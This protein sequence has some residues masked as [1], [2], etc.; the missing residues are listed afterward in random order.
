[1]LKQ[2]EEEVGGSP[3]LFSPVVEDIPDDIDETMSP[4]EYIELLQLGVDRRVISATGGGDTLVFIHAVEQGRICFHI[5][6][7]Y[8]YPVGTDFSL[9]IGLRW[10]RAAALGGYMQ[11]AYLFP[12]LQHQYPE[13]SP[14]P[15]Q[16]RLLLAVAGLTR[17][18]P[19][20]DILAS[21]WPAHYQQLMGVIQDQHTIQLQPGFNDVYHM[22]TIRNSKD[23]GQRSIESRGIWDSIMSY[24][25]DRARCLLEGQADN[26]K[27]AAT[28]DDD[29]AGVLHALTYLR[30][31]DAAFLA[32]LAVSKGADLNAM[33]PASQGVWATRLDEAT[34]TSALSPAIPRGQ[35]LFARTMID[36]HEEKDL[37]IKDF[38]R[39]LITSVV[40]W[41][42][43]LA[44]AL[45]ELRARRPSLCDGTPPAELVGLV[46]ES[47]VT[48]PRNLLLASMDDSDMHSLENRAFHGPRHDEAY[49]NTLMLLIKHGAN[50]TD[51]F[52][53]DCPLYRCL[54]DDDPIA[55]RCF[56]RYLRETYD[57]D[58]FQRVVDPGHCRGQSWSANGHTG[59][60]T[61]IYSG[62]VSISC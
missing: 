39:A 52:F 49:A 46:E 23:G 11:A 57:G 38:A 41:H 55:L 35:L 47:V 15:V 22:S 13:Q 40:Y 6:L 3:D 4:D 53:R 50:P 37:P 5:A 62:A 28:E 20:L 33:R 9:E 7:C 44:E 24:N 2:L 8:L 19:C 26:G 54:D 30:D 10:L 36:L 17:S 45:F 48:N 51:G 32:R 12:I 16:E 61:C 21:K 29:I 14:P 43:H 42:Y 1:M 31:A 60:Q 27:S 34:V 18:L 58:P 25:L 56:I 59:L